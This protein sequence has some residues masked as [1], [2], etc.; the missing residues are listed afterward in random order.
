M[1]DELEKN[2]KSDDNFPE[3]FGSASEYARKMS[4]RPLSY[5]CDRIDNIALSGARVLDAGCGSG[6]WSFALVPHFNEVHGIDYIKERTDL[7]SFIAEKYGINTTTFREGNILDT[8]FDD[9]YFDAVFC[10]GVIIVPQTPID[11][12]LKEFKRIVKPGG[13]IFVCLNAPGW[14]YYL[15][16]SEDEIRSNLGKKGI[17]V[18]FR[19]QLQS[20]VDAL[21]NSG[22]SPELEKAVQSGDAIQA[23]ASAFGNN[24]PVSEIADRIRADCGADFA[25]KLN[26]EFTAII[27]GAQDGFQPLTGYPATY[28]PE[29]VEAHAESL[30][31][32]GF[33]WAEEGRLLRASSPKDVTPIYKGLFEEKLANWEFVVKR[34]PE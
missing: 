9:N 20:I 23:L 18:H 29:E 7:C 31:F 12:A 15:A 10:F 25:K 28:T 22:A 19:N 27:N 24:V 5:F 34:K 8:G 6:N 16:S 17:Y 26:A 21:R 1:L 33:Q 30:G 4:K 3:R 11:L 14:A 32:Q 13:E 2:W